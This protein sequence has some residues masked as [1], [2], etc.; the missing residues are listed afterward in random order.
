M[1]QANEVRIQGVGRSPRIVEEL[2]CLHITFEK[3]FINNR[4]G[5]EIWNDE[6]SNVKI[7]K[8]ELFDFSIFEFIFYFYIFFNSSNP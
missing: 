5:V 1:S 8:I 6:I 4:V 7:I 2:L 3:L